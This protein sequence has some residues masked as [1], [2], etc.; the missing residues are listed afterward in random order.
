LRPQILTV[1]AYGD[2]TLD[3]PDNYVHYETNRKPE[4]IAKFA[5]GKIPAFEDKE[6]FTLF[7]A[8]P[9]ARYCE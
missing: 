5:S 4:Y 9:I 7:E 6:G 1:A 8:T 3:I 2:F